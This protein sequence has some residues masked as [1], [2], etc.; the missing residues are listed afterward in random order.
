M[1]TNKFKAGATFPVIEL[2]TLAGNSMLLG[3]PPQGADWRLLVVY[4]GKHCPLCSR[5]LTELEALKDKFLHIGVDI[6]AVSADS[7]DQ[8]VIEPI[9]NHR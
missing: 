5:Y 7:K 4:R 6:A 1:T 3:S 9:N 8:M 2:P